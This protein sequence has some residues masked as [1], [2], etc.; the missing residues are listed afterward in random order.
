MQMAGDLP[1]RTVVVSS[2]PSAARDGDARTR[3]AAPANDS[4][5]RNRR[6]VC[7]IAIG[8]LPHTGPRLRL[9]LSLQLVEET[10]IG[11]LCDELLR[12]VLDHSQLAHP[13]RVE[14]HRVLG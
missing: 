7:V 2:P 5:V 11:V 8:S 13:Q 14:A 9:Q 6:R 10:P 4:V 12:G 3:P 1:N